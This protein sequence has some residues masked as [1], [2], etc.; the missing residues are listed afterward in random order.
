MNQA[1]G[2]RYGTAPAAVWKANSATPTEAG[3]SISLLFQAGAIVFPAM[4]LFYR[5]SVELGAYLFALTFIAL[6]GYHLIRK[7]YVAGFTLTVATYPVLALLRTLLVYNSPIIIFAFWNAV[8]LLS[9]RSAR[10]RLNLNRPLK[11]LI[12]V[13]ILFWVA[14]WYLTGVYSSNFRTLEFVGAAVGLYLFAVHRAALATALVGMFF[15][16]VTMGLALLPYGDRLGMGEVNGTLFGN[17]IS[18]GVPLALVLLAAL[19]DDGK[20]MM[21]ENVKWARPIIFLTTGTLI[22]LSTSRATWAALL[23]DFLIVIAIGRKQRGPLLAM[24]AIAVLCFPLLMET[25]RGDVVQHWFDET[26]TPERGMVQATSGRSDMWAMF[27]EVF[28]DSPLYG[29]GPGMGTKVYAEYSAKNGEVHYDSGQ[30]AAWHAL[31]LQI[32][33]EGGLVGLVFLA[34]LFSA[35][36]WKCYQHW[37]ATSELMPLLAFFTYV[38]VSLTVSGLDGLSGMFMGMA[39]LS[40]GPGTSARADVAT[41]SYQSER[42]NHRR[43]GEL[44]SRLMEIDRNSKQPFTETEWLVDTPGRWSNSWIVFEGPDA[45]AFVIAD[46]DKEKDCLRIE[47]IGVAVKANHQDIGRAVLAIVAKNATEQN[48]KELAFVVDPD[49][50]VVLEFLQHFGFKFAGANG[51]TYRMAAVAT[52]V[53][54]SVMR[55]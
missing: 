33:V 1:V 13:G 55:A 42:L 6:G 10:H 43:I 54:Q 12:P 39:V 3:I 22:L 25:D 49:N 17:P 53:F 50:T 15:S 47:R 30:E 27:P 19:V 18:Y 2:P 45:R 34:F 16:L 36:A 21:L 32:G 8:L 46:H 5:G 11:I 37:L 40:C 9:D 31:P 51:P 52:Q 28:R 29:F 7:D 20:W 35:I 23:V 48:I 26:I 44:L 14:S 24:I 38:V 4:L 41:R